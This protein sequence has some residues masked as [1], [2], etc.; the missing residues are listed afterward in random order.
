MKALRKYEDFELCGSE[1]T[2]C[3]YCEESHLFENHRM[4]YRLE[5]HIQKTLHTRNKELQERGLKRKQ[6]MLDSREEFLQENK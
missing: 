2:W 5:A 6:S 4:N 1:S 3:K